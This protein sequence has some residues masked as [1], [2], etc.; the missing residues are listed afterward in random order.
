MA[1]KEI[2]SHDKITKN[3]MRKLYAKQRLSTPQI[4]KLIKRSKS[5][6]YYLLKKFK[7]PTRT[8]SESRMEYPKHK[9]SGDN[10]EYGYLLGLR[11][12]DIYAQRHR[13][14]IMMMTQTTH[15]SM[16]CLIHKVFEKYGH[17]SITP[18]H[19]F[20]RFGWH[21]RCFLD[22]SFSFLLN[23]L[24]SIPQDILDDRNMFI[25]FLSGY[26]D[27]EGCIVFCHSEDYLKFRLEILSTDSKIL[28]E[29]RH[30]LLQ[31]GYHPILKKIDRKIYKN[32]AML[33]CLYRKNEVLEILKELRLNHPEKIK[34]RK[35]LFHLEKC[36]KFSSARSKIEKLRSEIRDDVKKFSEVAKNKLINQTHQS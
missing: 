21:V 34:K 14:Q 3:L 31:F 36:K 12:G 17:V 27:A 30:K 10:S 24:K 4:A 15:P 35:L 8:I 13:K 29:I 9:F 26:F 22:N 19:V 18:V 20:D 5:A 16:V 2:N 7:I 6:V 1:K 25:D 28:E 11:T 33:L 32:G 23:K